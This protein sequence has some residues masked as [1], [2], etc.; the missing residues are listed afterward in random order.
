MFAARTLV[1]ANPAFQHHRYVPVRRRSL[2][3]EQSLASSLTWVTFEPNDEPIWL[4]IRTTI[5]DFMLGLFNQGAFQG[6]TPSEGSGSA[7][8][9]PPRP[10]STRRTAW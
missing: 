9:P 10:R 2:F 4:A 1:T 7:A 5:E 3:L 6:K 8:T